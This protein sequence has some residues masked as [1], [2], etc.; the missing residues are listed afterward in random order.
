MSTLEVRP[1]ASVTITVPTPVVVTPA[2]TE[3]VYSYG[4][5]SYA[6]IDH[7]AVYGWVAQPDLWVVDEEAYDVEHPAQQVYFQNFETNTTDG[8]GPNTGKLSNTL[9]GGSPLSQGQRSLTV[10]GNNTTATPTFSRTFTGLT[11]GRAY[12]FTAIGCALVPSSVTTT[13]GTLGVVGIGDGTARTLVNTEA[14][15]ATYTF[16]ATATSH[17]LRIVTTD[18]STGDVATWDNITL[19]RNAWTETIP[20]V[21]HWEEQPDLWQVV[22]PGYTEVTNNGLSGWSNGS[23]VSTFK[24]SGKY[25]LSANAPARAFGGLVVGHQ[26]TLRGW[27]STNGTT[28]TQYAETFTAAAT[29]QSKTLNVTGTRYWDDVTLTHAVPAATTLTPALPISEGKVRLDENY[30]PYVTANFSVP[31]TNRAL[32]EQV[33]PRKNQRVTVTT[34][35]GVSGVTRTYDLGLRSRKVNHKDQTVDIEVASDE[36]LLHD[37]KNGTTSV[38]TSPRQYEAN[39][40]SL[41]DNVLS[42][43]PSISRNL[44][45]APRGTTTAGFSVSVGGGTGTLTTA[46]TTGLNVG[47]VQGLDTFIRA[48]SSTTG[49]YIDVRN[50]NAYG[51][52]TGADKSATASVWV[53]PSSIGGVSGTVYLQFISA[54]G[55]TLSTTTS[56]PFALTSGDWT[57]VSVT[58]ANIP[59]TAVRMVAI[60][61]ATGTVAVGSRLDATGFLLE[62]S[63]RLNPFKDSILENGTATA[64][65]TARW[66][67]SNEFPNPVPSSITGYTTGTGT[68]AV[69][70]GT[71]FGRNAVRWTATGTGL[72]YLNIDTGFTVRPGNIY[73]LGGDFASSVARPVGFMLRWVNTDGV[74]I[75]DQILPTVTTNTS[76]WTNN[77]RTVVAPATA[78]K[79]A[80]FAL[81]S[82]NTAGQFHYVS[83]LQWFEGIETVPFYSGSDAPSNGYV[84]SWEGDV[85]ASPST[86][87]PANGVERLPELFHWKPGKSLFELLQPLLNASGLRL[88]C[89]E[90]RVWR[91]VD[92]TVYEVPGYVVAQTGFNATEGTDEIT[93]DDDTWADCVVVEYRWTATNGNTK[94]AYDAA[95]D[96]TGKTIVRELDRE[97]PGPGAAAAI[98]NSFKG[99]GRTQTVTVIGELGATPG[100]DVTVNLPGTVSQTGKL[101]AVTYDLSSGLTEVETRGLTDTLPGSWALWNPTQTWVQVNN[102]LKWK[103]A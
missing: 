86:R 78:A 73:T 65:M 4:F 31:L 56:T 92:P 90:L 24:R 48:E 23:V 87:T 9:W 10:G 13:T 77:T 59:A 5:E 70:Y 96:P 36:I 58:E 80:V 95:G 61:R 41:V 49:T 64:D 19:T 94:T 30:S 85:G 46:A 35:E 88:F 75:R 22:T 63:P 93:R 54:G 50:T 74:R 39:L 71:S 62:E 68:S 18:G 45:S 60:F 21:G 25:S 2:R 47:G 102:T 3:T 8:W 69:T 12:T 72:S 27:H 66:T 76:G 82:T 32:L 16:T 91:L 43:V 11:V 28:W 34:T 97:Y 1:E 40:R 17:T 98:L 79:V 14:R 81:S 6:S 44:I 7:P 67:V 29:S 83:R 57:R 52:L 84:Y 38:D 42:R 33:E 103:D 100:Q 99:R 20:A 101:R 89:D 51:N 53:R 15:T 26:Y 55:V 37:R